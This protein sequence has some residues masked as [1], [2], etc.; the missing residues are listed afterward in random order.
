[1][2]NPFVT[3][4]GVGNFL[5]AD[6]GFGIR[7]IEKLQADYRFPEEVLVVDGGVLGINLLGIVSQ[8]CHLIVVDA[9]RNRGNAGDLYRLAGDDIPRRVLAKNSLH[10]VDLLEALTLCQALDKVPET[11]ILGVEPEDIETLKLE[12][13]PVVQRQVAPMAARVLQELDRLGVTYSR[14]SC[15]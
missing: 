8:P 7:V 4:L 11:V 13:T 1:M 5:F 15:T 12:M 2:G 14:R 9:L 3:I 6:E 10:Q